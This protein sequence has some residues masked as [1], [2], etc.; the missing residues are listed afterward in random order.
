MPGTLNIIL[1]TKKVLSKAIIFGG[2]SIR[3]FKKTDGVPGNFQQ[4]FKVY[5]KNNIKCPRSSCNGYIK[6]ILVSSRSAFYCPKCQ[7]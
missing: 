3:N 6:R 2:S 5:G 7:I 4:N 1:Q